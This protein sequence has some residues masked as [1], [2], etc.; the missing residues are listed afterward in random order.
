VRGLERKAAALPTPA[1]DLALAVCAR[2][3]LRN[4]PPGV[5][6][7]TAENIFGGAG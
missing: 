7:V 2:E 1:S 3:E 6:A 5:I 4:V